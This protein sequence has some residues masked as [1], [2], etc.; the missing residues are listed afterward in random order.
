M[1]CLIIHEKVG[2]NYTNCITYKICDILKCLGVQFNRAGRSMRRQLRSEVLC[3]NNNNNKPCGV[4]CV[5]SE[6]FNHCHTSSNNSV[7]MLLFFLSQDQ[8]LDLPAITDTALHLL[9][10]TPSS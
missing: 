3:I 2:Q 10:H 8:I 1:V 6:N 7:S 4:G 9:V 5:V